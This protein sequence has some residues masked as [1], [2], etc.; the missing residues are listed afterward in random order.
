MVLAQ[1]QVGEGMCVLSSWL[2]AATLNIT[3]GSGS[4]A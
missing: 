4:L 1:A 3:E 2:A